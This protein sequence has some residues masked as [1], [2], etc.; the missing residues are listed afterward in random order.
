MTNKYKKYDS[1]IQDAIIK[2]GNI[3]LY[4]EL[5][6]PRSTAM[7]WI[8]TAKK[9]ITLKEFDYEAAYKCRI[10]KLEQDLENEKAKTIFIKDLFMK[11]SNKESFYSLKKNKEVLVK[12]IEKYKERLS[13][14]EMCRI[15]GLLSNSYYRYKIDIL[16]CPR[17]SFKKCKILSPNQLTFREQEKI[18]NLVNDKS[19]SHLSIK[20]LQFHAFRNGILSCGYDSWRKYT[21]EFRGEGRVVRKKKY[22]TGI[23][24]KKVNEIWHIDITQF[25]LKDGK[26]VYLQ[27]IMDN[28]SRKIISYPFLFFIYCKVILRNSYFSRNE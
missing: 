5:K 8:R 17:I 11:F 1:S 4:P 26:V 9:K 3:N 20:G 10:K 19:L 16:G 24:A 15:L 23:R 6:I 2:S 12:V 22:R 18:H 7:S 27:A 13:V 14:S 28:F 21:K 25:R